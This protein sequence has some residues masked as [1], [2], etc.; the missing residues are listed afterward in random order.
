MK[1]V[2][3]VQAD[4]VTVTL[5]SNDTFVTITDDTEDF[6]NIAGGATISMEDAFAFDIAADVP[7]M[8]TI[9]FEV[10]AQGQDTWSSSFSIIVCAPALAMDNYFIND[11]NHSCQQRRC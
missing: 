3:T 11:G 10:Q 5:S 8:H 7:D 1:N 9:I 2:G 6:G 4:N